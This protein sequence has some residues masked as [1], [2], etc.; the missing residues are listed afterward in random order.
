MITKNRAF[1][2]VAAKFGSVKVRLIAAFG[3]VAGLTLCAAAVS[4]FAFSNI[5]NSLHV[6]AEEAAPAITNALRLSETSKE[7]AAA[8]PTL[9]AANDGK[10]LK[11]AAD[12]LA[13]S[14]TGLETNMDLVE[15]AANDHESVTRLRGIGVDISSHLGK[16]N[17]QMS[18]RLTLR[19]ERLA[20]TQQIALT[21]R[22]LLEA[23]GPIINKANVDLVVK[24]DDTVEE[25][26]E[27]LQELSQVE[28]VNLRMVLQFRADANLAFGL[29]REAAG[30]ADKDGISLARE[31]FAE[32][33]TKLEESIEKLDD[34]SDA[35]GLLYMSLVFIKDFDLAEQSVFTAREKELTSPAGQRDQARQHLE[36]ILSDIQAGHSEFLYNTESLVTDAN[37]K[38][39]SAAEQTSEKL[40]ET[41]ESLINTEVRGLRA[42]LELKAAANEIA[43]VL[44]Q[45]AAARSPKQGQQLS[46]RF[47]KLAVELS[48][49]V[50]RLPKSEAGKAVAD[51]AYQ[52]TQLG[53]GKGSVIALRNAELAL[54]QDIAGTMS[55]SR[56]LAGQLGAEVNGLVEG[57]ETVLDAAAS[58]SEVAIDNGTLALAVITIVSF[59]VT[60]LIGWL[61][62]NRNV[63][64]RLINISAVMERLAKG[65]LSVEITANGNDE[66][67]AMARTVDVF[68][69]NA[70]EKQRM[71]A[72]QKDAERRAEEDR[73]KAMLEL[74]QRFEES[75]LGIVETVS[76]ASKEVETTAQSMLQ[77][78]DQNANYSETVA[79][80]SEHAAGNVESVSVATDELTRSVDEIAQQAER[81]NQISQEAVAE[82]QSATE[83][84]QGLVTAAE[85][86]GTVVDMISD[87]ANQTNLLALNATIEAARAGE[88]GKGFA[89]VA[90][91]V[92]N[93]AT[94]T[95][96]AT[97]E[98]DDKIREIQTA[99]GSAVTVIGGVSKTI[100]NI[101]GIASTIA[102]AVGEQGSATA[103]IS[104]N[105]GEATQSTGEVNSN[106][107]KIKSGALK[108]RGTAD[109]MLSAARELSKESVNLKDE[110]DNFLAG[111]RA[112]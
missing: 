17:K 57:A 55:E 32:A 48:N 39:N 76:T 45:A 2:R 60:V 111:V 6:V 74:A 13:E 72:E 66:I 26:D 61:Y 36:G 67:S 28:I 29:L 87:I 86:I 73:R 82:V 23:V 77:M 42:M 9:T 44:L 49:A 69:E 21:H 7:I 11:S 58:D 3:I 103:E 101:S 97:D 78:A 92:K 90:S 25:A 51:L 24:S 43:G 107:A 22:Q 50:N 30:A 100:D 84:V 106:V 94:Q 102:A 95:A 91:E 33:V 64:T 41:F 112:G 19:D 96:K 81:S 62:I 59:L 80:E 88:A 12:A 1:S 47:D 56:T 79:E 31:R 70:L 83:E 85:H 99:T 16:L 98:I 105:V 38:I 15:A 53:L 71:E 54:D 14:Q 93:L 104:R 68:K 89:V 18:Q 4:Y 108:N 110:V 20:L 109:Q 8:I 75:V 46:L 37:D 63:S 27:A 10:Q 65:D 5:S 35:K 34:T 40:S 52:L